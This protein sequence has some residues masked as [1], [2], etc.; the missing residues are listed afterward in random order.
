MHQSQILIKTTA[1]TT[2]WKDIFKDEVTQRVGKLCWILIE[3]VKSWE[4]IY[5]NRLPQ[6][7]D[8]IDAI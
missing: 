4:F 8:G 3:H 2:I 5:W 6:C 7:V 1:T